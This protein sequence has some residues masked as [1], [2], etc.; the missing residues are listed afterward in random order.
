MKTEILVSLLVILCLA[1]FMLLP[2]FINGL[3]V[4]EKNLISHDI[5]SSRVPDDYESIIAVNDNIAGMLHYNREKTDYD[6]SI[7]KKH[8]GLHFGY[9]FCTGGSVYDIESN[10]AVFSD[11]YDD[12]TI[13]ISLN[14]PKISRIEI[15]GE[16]N[17]IVSIDE[18]EPFVIIVPPKAE[19]KMFE[20][21]G[22]EVEYR[23]L[24]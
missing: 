20:T 8:S 18:N 21:N 2:D 24:P 11:I 12:E 23:T 13:L 1:T 5:E 15:Y 22:N 10:V 7:Y 6:F 4:S 14:K 17:Q 3:G 19:F 9:F 16:E